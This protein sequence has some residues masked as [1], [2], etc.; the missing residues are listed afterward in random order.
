MKKHLI[1]SVMLSLMC[2]AM[3]VSSAFGVTLVAPDGL[4]GN[5]LTELLSEGVINGA[6]VGGTA[7]E[8]DDSPLKFSAENACSL[9][10][11]I[12]P[13]G[14][15]LLAFS[16]PNMGLDMPT[17]PL[18][19]CVYGTVADITGT[20]TKEYT[21]TV[22]AINTAGET[23]SKE[24][25]FKVYPAPQIADTTPPAIEWG[26]PYTFTPT[27]YNITEWGDIASEGLDETY[28]K[29]LP[30]GLEF[31]NGTISGTWKAED[32]P[33]GIAFGSDK[34][35]I[36]RKIRL[37]ALQ[38]EK[39]V[40]HDYTLTF[41]ATAPVI[42]EPEGDFNKLLYGEDCEIKVKAEGSGVISWTVDKLPA[43]LE[44]EYESDGTSSVLTI[45][46][47]PTSILKA[48]EV[49]ITAKNSAGNAQLK[50]KATVGYEGELAFA[51]DT[52]DSAPEGIF[53]VGMAVTEDALEDDGETVL[54]DDREINYT[55]RRFEIYPGPITWTIT[56]LPSG[57][58]LSYDKK[59]DGTVA[60]LIG[61]FD[62]ASKLDKDGKSI[63][64]ITATNKLLNNKK[65]EISKNLVVYAKPSITT[66]KLADLTTGKN[67]NQKLT[68]T[69]NPTK[70][71][72]S[73]AS[74]KNPNNDDFSEESVYSGGSEDDSESVV[75]WLSS[76]SSITG[77]LARIPEGGAFTVRATAS[78]VAGA[79]TKTYTVNV[80]GTAPKITTTTLGTM[81]GED[82]A[83]V[84]ATGTLPITLS[85]YID[86]KTAKSVF[87]LDGKKT[88]DLTD[89][90]N[91]TG[92]T[93]APSEED[94]GTGTITLASEAGVS[95]KNLPITIAALN[96]ATTKA[97]TK[98]LKVNVTGTAPKLYAMID[99][100]EAEM[101][102]DLTFNVPAGSSLAEGEGY[103]FIVRGDKPVTVTTSPNTAKNGIS[104][105]IEA[106]DEGYEITIAGTP[107]SGKDTKTTITLTAMNPSTKA[108][109][110]KK[111]IIAPQLPP[112]ITTSGKAL[113]KEAEAGK[114]LSLALAAKGTKPITWSITDDDDGEADE[115]LEEY[116]LTFDSKTGKIT[117]KK[118]AKP[119]VEDEEYSPVKFKVIAS[120]IAGDS[121][122]VTV[123][124]GIKGSKPKFTTKTITIKRTEPDLDSAK[125]T[126]DIKADDTTANVVYSITDQE[127]KK[128]GVIGLALGES[129]NNQ[130]SL[131]AEGD[132]IA[133][134]GTNI[135]FTASN[136]GNAVTGSVKIVI[137]DPKPE[138]EEASVEDMQ[139]EQ[140]K[141]T[142]TVNLSLTEDTKPTGNT[143][144]K[145]AIGKK[146]LVKGVS[147]ALKADSSTAGAKLTITV[148][149]KLKVSGTNTIEITAT[150]PT[151]KEKG[152][153]T[154]TFGVEAYE[155][156]N[157][158]LPTK[159]SSLP[160]DEAVIP[161]VI[162][163]SETPDDEETQTEG[164]ALSAL[165]VLARM[166][167]LELA[168]GSR[169]VADGEDYIVAAVLPEITVEESGQYDLELE[170][171]ENAP[172]G[173]R[174][175]WLAL[176]KDAEPSEDD[177]II[178]F[179]DDTGADTET[180]PANHKLIASPWLRA[181]IVYSPV[182]MVKED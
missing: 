149:A 98:A 12:S 142:Q 167:G 39:S 127:A 44:Y 125:L 143:K 56:N 162:T 131:T 152:E 160:E 151:T 20:D 92:F 100:D 139:A 76:T 13:S 158:S 177:T 33:E 62:K 21:I 63:Y 173:A 88:I 146:T 34:K 130:A 57:L 93:F 140:K 179:Y 54:Q 71:T 49:V 70:W 175:Y 75:Q 29:D 5:N 85:A 24:Y 156:E 48:Q 59:G 35:E 124:I 172:E 163:D 107:T 102:K 123:S 1:K 68:A 159:K 50:P 170:L 129:E 26:K 138:I 32:D 90:E 91:I 16:V 22:T 3:M 45:T 36:T 132:L 113:V 155:A 67:Y 10:V 153:V 126:T 165:E 40:F 145:W 169:V 11:N 84:K 87:G 128:L 4:T 25:I 53:A 148:P 157:S 27:A 38:E 154:L 42:E 58:T 147:V 55:A 109:A 78:N 31:N 135:K 137:T 118:A 164:E 61:K 43:G 15:G 176:P 66:T 81:K 108:K 134:T 79:D 7:I 182:I 174:L 150:N 180:V 120:N 47:S 19:A 136:Y 52:A 111:V 122:P 178:D 46:G 41:K 86:A 17:L 77:T 119:T 166:S 171:D 6:A 69:N 37:V 161:E 74:G 112:T 60:E 96:G 94:D 103:K 115:L 144:I 105:T 51:D 80:K 99:G 2:I 72:V 104:S 116:G 168:A 28:I 141:T 23:D 181:D 14:S 117:T 65:A 133:S 97:V 121:A 18:Q 89:E 83:E 8:Y 82:T 73:F 101:S 110:S 64:K 114:S 95:Y 30:E 106:T 9:T